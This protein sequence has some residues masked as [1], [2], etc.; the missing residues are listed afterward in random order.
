MITGYIFQIT[1]FLN[2]YCFSIKKDDSDGDTY[3]ILS[4]REKRT[5]MCALTKKVKEMQKKKHDMSL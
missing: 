1:S 3:N 5:Y 2:V 4:Q